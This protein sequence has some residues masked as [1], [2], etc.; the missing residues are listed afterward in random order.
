MK[1]TYFNQMSKGLK[2]A[3]VAYP[4][5][6]IDKERLDQNISHLMKTVNKGLD[7]RIVAK[8]L[9]CVELLKYIMS[10]TKTTRLMCF[11]LP[12]IMNVVQSIKGAD[13]LLGKP[14]PTN[15]V[16]QF[17]QWYLSNQHILGFDHEKQMQWLVDSDQR[18]QKYEA[19]ATAL[20]ITLN[21][22]LEIDIGLHRGGYNTDKEFRQSLQRIKSSKALRLSG[23]MGYEAYITKV[24]A[25]LGGP[26]KAESES[27]ARYAHFKK[28]TESVIDDCSHL[29]FN[30]GGSTTYPLYEAGD[31]C[32][33]ISVASALV[34][35][36][37]FDVY[38]LN[39]H[40]PAAFIATP[41]LKRVSNPEFP[42][43]KSISTL[44]RTIGLLPKL[45]CFIYGGNWLASPYYPEQ[46]KRSTILGPSSNQEMYSLPD[47]CELQEDDYM[48]FRPSQSEAVFLQF[49]K[50]AIYEHGKII[51]W[52][53]VFNYPD[54]GNTESKILKTA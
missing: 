9:P 7:Y 18:L 53:P 24:P 49:G 28:L 21:V 37:D 6:V 42:A 33:E 54:L 29:C 17:Y 52:W 10:K 16:D 15:A 14:M 12:F 43:A 46:S 31:S 38:T 4:T 30:T 48:F 1:K 44:L 51:N 22:N 34:K 50:I 11:H 27:K 8:S 26:K 2:L 5:L 19:L 32:N 13:I 39:H 47:Y 3:G 41:I 40:Q 25:L 20:G 35:P 23:L 36:S 45:A